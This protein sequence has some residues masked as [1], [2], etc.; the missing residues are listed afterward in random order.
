MKQIRAY[1][2]MCAQEGVALLG[3]ERGG[4]HCRLVFERGYVTAA[5]TPSDNRNMMNVRGSIRRLHR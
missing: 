3:I 5:V 4:K 1:R 2:K